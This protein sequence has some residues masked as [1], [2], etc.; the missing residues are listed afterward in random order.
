[1]QKPSNDRK[2]VCWNCGEDRGEE[3]RIFKEFGMGD[4]GTAYLHACRSCYGLIAMYLIMAYGPDCIEC[5][6]CEEWKNSQ[7]AEADK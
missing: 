7:K 4:G 2:T 1:M 5:T 6:A 3:T